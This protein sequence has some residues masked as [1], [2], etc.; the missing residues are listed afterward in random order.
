MTDKPSSSAATAL[1]LNLLAQAAE[2]SARENDDSAMQEAAE[3]AHR[4]AQRAIR[5]GKAGTVIEGETAV[6]VEK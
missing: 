4:L 3:R 2:Q 6:I 1:R 5:E